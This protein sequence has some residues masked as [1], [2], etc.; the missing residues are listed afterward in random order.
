[1]NFERFFDNC[2]F[3]KMRLDTTKFNTSWLE[4]LDLDG[5]PVKR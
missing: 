5:T 2:T 3:V 4:K 1:M